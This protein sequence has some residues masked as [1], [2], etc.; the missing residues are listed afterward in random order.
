MPSTQTL[1]TFFELEVKKNNNAELRVEKTE[2]K[3]I[4]ISDV[5]QKNILLY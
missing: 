1:G 2:S 5:T 4:L 3:L